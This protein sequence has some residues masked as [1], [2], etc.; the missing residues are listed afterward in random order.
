MSVVINVLVNETF[1]VGRQFCTVP[2]QRPVRRLFDGVRGSLRRKRE[3][4]ERKKRGGKRR[5]KREKKKEERGRRE[6]EEGG[7][8]E[9]RRRGRGFF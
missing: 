3:G 8:R 7:R 5:K 4:R 9:G 2:N 6:G 1:N